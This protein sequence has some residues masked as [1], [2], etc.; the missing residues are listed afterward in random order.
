M[1]KPPLDQYGLAASGMEP[2]VDPPFN[3]VF[4]GSM[5][6]FRGLLLFGVKSRIRGRKPQVGMTAWA[7]QF[8]AVPELPE[9]PCRANVS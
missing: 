3:R 8:V 9:L 5:S 1:L 2:I 4:V 7:T 6:L